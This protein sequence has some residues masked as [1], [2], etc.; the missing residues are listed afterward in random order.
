MHELLQFF[1]KTI[2]HPEV[3]GCSIEYLKN[4]D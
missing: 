3:S 2:E 4:L 1:I